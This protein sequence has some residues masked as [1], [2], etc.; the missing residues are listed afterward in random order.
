MRRIRRCGRVY[1]YVKLLCGGNSR[2]IAIAVAAVIRAVRSDVFPLGRLRELPDFG[3][4]NSALR[5]AGRRFLKSA[6]G[7]GRARVVDR[8]V[9]D[10][11]SAR[12]S[13]DIFGGDDVAVVF[14]GDARAVDAGAG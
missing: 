12:A 13:A 2:R 4:G 11:A 10:V 6:A 8:P 5:G 3:E 1:V 9:D 14:R 7:S